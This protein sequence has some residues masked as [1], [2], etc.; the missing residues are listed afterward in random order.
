MTRPTYPQCYAI[1]A[2]SVLFGAPGGVRDVH[3]QVADAAQHATT[4]RI[5]DILWKPIAG[6]RVQ[7]RGRIIRENSAGRFMFADS[8]GDITAVIAEDMLLGHHITE[9]TTVLIQGTVG[10]DFRSAPE[11]LVSS[12]SIDR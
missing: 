8:S 1:I 7:L 10:I 5:A 3:A 11:I 12:L 9:F 6:Q 2:A 4:T